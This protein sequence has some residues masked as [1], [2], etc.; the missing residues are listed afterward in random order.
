MHTFRLMSIDLEGS[1]IDSGFCAPGRRSPES[2]C[3]R[4]V[5]LFAKSIVIMRVVCGTLLY[6][7][8][9][10]GALVAQPGLDSVII[11]TYYISDSNDAGTSFFPV[12]AGAMTYRIYVDMA[13]DWGLQAIMVRPIAVPTKWSIRYRW[14]P[15]SPPVDQQVRKLGCLSLKIPM[16]AFLLFQT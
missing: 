15:G 4:S 7:L 1:F 10:G 9:F 13:P 5:K 11:E 12:P 2:Y 8:F 6:I 14:I 16:E 3:F